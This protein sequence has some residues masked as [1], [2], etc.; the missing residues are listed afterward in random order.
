MPFATKVRQF[1]RELLGSRYIVQ[2]ERDLVVQ[3]QDFEQRLAEKDVLIAGLRHKGALQEGELDQMRLILMPMSSAA[4]AA[5]SRA[6]YVKNETIK[7]K[8][9]ATTSPRLD[10]D[11]QTYLKGRVEQME[12]DDKAAAAKKDS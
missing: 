2:L 10:T 12:Q 8:V 11:W 3:R 6:K 4:G 5:Y 7:P 1:F 9:E